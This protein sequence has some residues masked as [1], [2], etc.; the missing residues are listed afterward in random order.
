M[1]NS[2]GKIDDVTFS[3]TEQLSAAIYLDFTGFDQKCLIG[4]V[5]KV[6][7]GNVARRHEKPQHGKSV[8]RLFRTY[9]NMRFLPKRPYNMAVVDSQRFGFNFLVHGS[10]KCKSS[11]SHR[12]FASISVRHGRSMGL[13]SSSE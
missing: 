11:S 13:V 5:M 4:P 3:S 10:Y 7:R 6:R 2:F 1:G 9:E 12:V 8:S